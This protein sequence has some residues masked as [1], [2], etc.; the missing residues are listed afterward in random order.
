VL[1]LCHDGVGS[2]GSGCEMRPCGVGVRSLCDSGAR[3]KT[4]SRWGQIADQ[5]GEQVYTTSDG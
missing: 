1:M 4:R 3:S 2:V 5:R